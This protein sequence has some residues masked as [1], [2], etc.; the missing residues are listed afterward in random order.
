MPTKLTLKESRNWHKSIGIERTGD[1]TM[2]TKFS[3]QESRWIND[4]QI[5]RPRKAK[6]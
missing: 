5:S 3:K 4:N 6:S 2:G 1:V